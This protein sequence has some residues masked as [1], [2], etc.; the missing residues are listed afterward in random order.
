MVNIGETNF[1]KVLSV[2][3]NG[4]IHVLNEKALIDIINTG[5]SYYFEQFANTGLEDFY[6]DFFGVL[7]SLNF[8][9]E[10]F[11]KGEFQSYSD[12]VFG[13][14]FFAPRLPESYIRMFLFFGNEKPY[15]VN[16]VIPIYLSFYEAFFKQSSHNRKFII[17]L[18]IKYANNLKKSFAESLNVGRVNQEEYKAFVGRLDERISNLE[19]AYQVSEVVGVDDSGK[20]KIKDEVALYQLLNG[21]SNVNYLEKFV[22]LNSKV[23]ES[24]WRYEFDFLIEMI[25]L[26]NYKEWNQEQIEYLFGQKSGLYVVHYMV[27]DAPNI[28]DLFLRMY[29]FYFPM[30]KPRI[31][32]LFATKLIDDSTYRA[33][34]ICMDRILNMSEV[35]DERIVR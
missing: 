25:K 35:N 24:A 18:Y 10:N 26:L 32:D 16:F 23:P 21:L 28:A 6:L 13:R 1:D 29:K 20:V 8:V 22:F 31:D 17:D 4:D 11:R 30:L 3:N 9:A 12:D 33:L 19:G 5:D 15:L 27:D 2:D 34:T 7:H 14:N